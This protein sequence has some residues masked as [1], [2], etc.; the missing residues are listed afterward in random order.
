MAAS[1][2]VRA[3]AITARPIILKYFPPACCVAASRIT[4]ECLR[5][6]GIR[7]EATQVKFVVH[8]KALNMAYVAG[9]DEDE[10]EKARLK[11]SDWIDRVPDNLVAPWNGHVVVVTKKMPSFLIDPSFDQAVMPGV[12]IPPYILAAPLG[13]AIRPCDVGAD[14]QL[15]TDDGLTLD[16]RYVPSSD[17]SFLDTPAW[18]RDHILPVADEICVAM[19]RH[20]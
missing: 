19:R 11:A 12:R 13:R 18:D 20:L 6:F 15:K 10:R 9:L 17:R 16:V 1:E 14:L 3:F 7:S 8:V 2:I 5:R 4:V